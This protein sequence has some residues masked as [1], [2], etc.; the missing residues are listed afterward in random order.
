MESP[1]GPISKEV[2]PI[3]TVESTVLAGQNEINGSAS[4]FHSITDTQ[5][6]TLSQLQSFAPKA[7]AEQSSDVSSCNKT[8]DQTVGTTLKLTQSETTSIHGASNNLIEPSSSRSMPETSS[9]YPQADSVNFG[10]RYAPHV[11]VSYEGWLKQITGYQP[12]S[13]N[14]NTSIIL[15]NGFETVTTDPNQI[16]C[17][18]KIAK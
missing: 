9:T 13:I 10:Y 6:L 3:N 16:L 15:L 7:L 14:I 17:E 8:S 5:Q 2:A 4:S 12:R 11:A 18:K 1:Q